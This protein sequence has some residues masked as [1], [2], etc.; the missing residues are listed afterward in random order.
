MYRLSK[1]FISIII[2]VLTTLSLVSCG[3][4]E[5]YSSTSF[6][7]FNTDVYVS[8]KGELDEQTKN[9]IK[10]T[11]FDLEN[12]VSLTRDGS[13]IK[14]F[15]ENLSTTVSDQTAYL[16]SRVKECF[17]LTLGK[18]NPAVLPLLDLYRLSSSTYE[19]HYIRYTP[20]LE[21]YISQLLPLCDFSAVTLDQ[22]NKILSKSKDGIKID[23]GGIAKGYAVDLIKEI[24]SNKGFLEGFINVGGSSI[25]VLDYNKNL[26]VK[27]PRENGKYILSIDCKNIKNSPLST[28]G[29]YV[30]CYIDD[31]GNRYSHIIDSKTGKTVNTGFSSVTLIANGEIQENKKSAIFTDA[32]STSLMLMEKQ[33]MIDFVKSNL[34]GFTV[35][36]VYEK[37]GIRQ[38]ITNADESLYSIVDANYSSYKF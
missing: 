30:R 24:L 37:D 32:L 1:I 22:E 10:T 5:S 25:Y 23:L 35:Y 12:K 31:N 27:H 13:D 11:L 9:E 29:D 2:L 36:A 14:K 7:C 21:I 38:I 3:K 18:F 34:S 33:E 17:D 26:S 28:S 20:P 16:I 15:N 8:V 6:T 19:T 4:G